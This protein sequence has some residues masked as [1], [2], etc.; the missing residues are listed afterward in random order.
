MSWLGEGIGQCCGGAGGLRAVAGMAA[1]KIGYP[2][3][4]EAEVFFGS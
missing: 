3:D 1:W 4:A 2:P